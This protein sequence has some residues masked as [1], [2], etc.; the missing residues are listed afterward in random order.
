MRKSISSILAIQRKKLKGD[1][2]KSRKVI[3]QDIGTCR[4]AG[5]QGG[6]VPEQLVCLYIV[7]WCWYWHWYWYKHWYWYCQ[8]YWHWYAMVL[9]NLI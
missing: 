1:I 6:E 7:H 3:F 9:S 8:W 5:A 2:K 4:P